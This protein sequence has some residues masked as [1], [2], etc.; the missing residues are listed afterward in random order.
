[1]AQGAIVGL[2]TP[3]H[4]WPVGVLSL[5]WNSMGG[6]DYTMTHTRNAAWL[7]QM[8]PEQMAWIDGFPLW[9]N[10]CW[11]LGVWGAVLGSILLLLRKAWAVPAFALSLAGIAG[12]TFFQYGVPGMPDS[13]N[14]AGGKA[15]CAALW[16][17][18]IFLLWYAIAMRKR[19]VIR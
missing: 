13:L 1:M 2:R 12:T 17:V 10:F 3:W 15:F 6:L 7:A 19:G 14:T 5:L 4:Y 11:G 9:A 16:A 8:T 18:A